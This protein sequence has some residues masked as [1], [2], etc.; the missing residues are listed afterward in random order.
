MAKFSFYTSQDFNSSRTDLVGEC[1]IAQVGQLFRILL[2]QALK[3]EILNLPRRRLL[4]HHYSIRS[5]PDKHST[6]VAFIDFICLEPR[7]LGRT[8]RRHPWVL[9]SLRLFQ[10]LIYFGPFT[11]TEIGEKV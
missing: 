9:R 6:S 11:A 5:R 7:G 10:G 4:Y 3:G 8:E 2:S 1:N